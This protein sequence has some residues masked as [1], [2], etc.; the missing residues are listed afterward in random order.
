MHKRI[1]TTLSY[2]LRILSFVQCTEIPSYAYKHNEN[3]KKKKMGEISLQMD[4]NWL[5]EST[6]KLKGIKS[7]TWS[8]KQDPVH[9]LDQDSKQ[10]RHTNC[11][12]KMRQDFKNTTC[13]YLLRNE[14]LETPPHRPDS[15]ENI[16]T[17]R[18]NATH[19]DAW[20]FSNRKPCGLKMGARQIMFPFF[21][22]CE[23]KCIVLQFSARPCLII[24][25]MC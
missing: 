19:S 8:R 17:M 7:P 24:H 25:T 18:C 9:N 20:V 14:T 1:C 13:K 4:S 15:P 11:R 5:M 12:D 16:C 6:W 23:Y 2:V 21:P 22:V 10:I 3:K